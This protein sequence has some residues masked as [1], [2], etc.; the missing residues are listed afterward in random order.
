[1]I[2]DQ[3]PQEKLGGWRSTNN[4]REGRVALGQAEPP[5][6]SKSPLRVN[7][8]DDRRRTDSILIVIGQ[9]REVIGPRAVHLILIHQSGLLEWSTWFL[10]EGGIEQ[11][12]E[13][14]DRKKRHGE[15]EPKHPG[16]AESLA[17]QEL[18]GFN[19]EARLLPL[20]DVPMDPAD[21]S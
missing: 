3:R 20:G 9:H 15:A 16:A 4:E 17:C 18:G 13:G 10:R 7:G 5:G 14:Q 11:G 2:S 19:H 12:Q 1:M 6:P 8:L 21:G